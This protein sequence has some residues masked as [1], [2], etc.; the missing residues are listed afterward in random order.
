[1][2][3][4]P[5]S[6]MEGRQLDLSLPGLTSPKGG[7][8]IDKVDIGQQLW[9]PIL[10]S[11]SHRVVKTTDQVGLIHSKLVLFFN[12][13]FVCFVYMCVHG[14]WSDNSLGDLVLFFHCV[15]SGDGLIELRLSGSTTSIV[16]PETFCWPLNWNF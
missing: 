12:A 5:L 7:A 1:M 15:S 2:D 8:D 14:P 9:A 13:L 3:M 4:G 11:P 10:G 16:T 6:V